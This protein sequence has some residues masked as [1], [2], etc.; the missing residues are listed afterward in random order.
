MKK[1]SIPPLKTYIMRRKGRA[2]CFTFGCGVDE[3][4]KIRRGEITD[5]SKNTERHEYCREK[6][7]VNCSIYLFFV[8]CSGKSSDEDAHPDEDG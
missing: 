1:T 5:G 6:R 7:L 4:K 3:I 8:T 2:S